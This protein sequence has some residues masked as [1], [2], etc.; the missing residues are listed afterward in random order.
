MNALDQRSQR[1]PAEIYDRLFVPALFA[2]WGPVVA[3][4]AGVGAGDRV[5]DV[6]C[7]TGAAT[8][9]AARAGRPGRVGRRARRQPR[10]AGG[11]PPQGRAR[12]TGATARPRRCRSP[13]RAS[14]R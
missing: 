12:S 6:A 4:A 5:L 13:T 14:T 7:G 10:H 9:A 11:R 1:T 8:L 3:E 2:R